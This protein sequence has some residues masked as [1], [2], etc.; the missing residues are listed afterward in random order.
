M[1][2]LPR[3]PQGN[4]YRY[5]SGCACVPTAP[6][7]LQVSL[8]LGTPVWTGGGPGMMRAASEGGLRAG[9]PVGGIRI[10][11]EAGTNVL[12]MEVRARVCVRARFVCVDMSRVF[13]ISF[14]TL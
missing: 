4:P 6:L 10:S 11:R 12:T 8:L 7:L 14:F 5:L 9:V 13:H 1:P 3:F 2:S